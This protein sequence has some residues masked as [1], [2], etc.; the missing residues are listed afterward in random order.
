VAET[1]KIDLEENSKYRVTL[2]LVR[3]IMANENSANSA[4]FKSAQ[5]DP[6]GYLLKLYEQCRAVVVNG[7]SAAYATKARTE[8]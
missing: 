3:M 4:D 6:R 1:V 2:E 8:N 5:T 7:S